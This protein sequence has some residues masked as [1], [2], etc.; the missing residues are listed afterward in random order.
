MLNWFDLEKIKKVLNIYIWF[1]FHVNV[2]K[3][4]V[5]DFLIS[6]DDRS[7]YYKSNETCLIE[8]GLK[9]VKLC[10]IYEI[11]VCMKLGLGFMMKMVN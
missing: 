2:Y 5:F 1:D 8:N 7:W 4:D 11:R 3:V 10:V 9:M 6:L